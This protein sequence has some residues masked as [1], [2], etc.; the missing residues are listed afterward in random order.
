MS[1][2]ARRITTPAWAAT[3]PASI[4][5]R[6]DNISTSTASFSIGN[7]NNYSSS[8]NVFAPTGTWLLQGSFSNYE[9]RLAVTS[10]SFGGASTGVWLGLGTSR[11]WQNVAFPGTSGYYNLVRGEGLLEIRT[12]ATQVVVASTVL[13]VQALSTDA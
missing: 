6:D 7:S 9:V 11:T 12:S 1:F 5:V 13:I 10:G 8:G 2:A 4:A 3:L